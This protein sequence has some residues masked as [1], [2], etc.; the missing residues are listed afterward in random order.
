MANPRKIFLEGTE[1]LSDQVAGALLEGIPSG[2]FD[3]QGTEVW[4]PTSGAARRIRHSLAKISEGKGSGVLSPKFSKPMSALLPLGTSIASRTDREAAWGIVL[5]DVDKSS[6][7]TLF[8]S[9]EVLEGEQ[10]LV[11]A[12]GMMCEL[13]DRLAEGG[14]TPLHPKISEVCGEDADRWREMDPIY[15]SYL[16]V[17]AHHGLKDPNE[18]KVRADV[19]IAPP[20]RLFIACVPDLQ[21]VAQ[22]RASLLMDQGVEVSV[23]VWRPRSM[24]GSFDTWGRPETKEWRDAIIPLTEDQI[25]MAKDPADEASRVVE[26]L[27]GGAGSHALVLGD[28]KI[29][30]AMQGEILR[31]GGSPF[32][33]EGKPL[34]R[35]EAS[36]VVAEWIKFRSDRS[37]RTLRR[38]LES[39]HFSAWI[40]ARCGLSTDQLLACSDWFMIDLLAENLS[41]AEAF[42]KV[43]PRDRE[44]RFLEV[45]SESLSLAPENLVR[46]VWVGDSESIEDVLDACTEV[47]SSKVASNWPEAAEA[48]LVRSFAR[49]CVYSSSEDG[50]T[51]LNGWL[52][53][54]WNAA[55]RLAICGCVEGCLPSTLDGHPFLPD[56]ARAALGI[57][58]NA[59]LRA[60][61][62]Y[63]LTCLIHAQAAREG[64]K[65]LCSFSKF[66]PDGSPSTPSGLLLKCKEEE[67]PERVVKLFGKSSAGDS[68][69]KRK[70][71]WTWLLPQKQQK[72]VL[73]ISPTDFKSYLVCPFR[74]YLSRRLNLDVHDQGVREMDGGQF[75]DLVHVVLRRFAEHSRDETGE[76]EISRA[77]VSHLDDLVMERFGPDPSPAVRVQIQAAKVRLQSFARVQSLLRD[78]GWKII[79]W[80]KKI[81]A[82][83][84]ESPVIGG[85]PLSAVIDRIDEHPELGIRII[86]YK[87]QGRPVTPEKAH[88]QGKSFLDE[89]LVPGDGK[90]RYWKDLQLPLYRKIA[91]VLYPDRPLECAYLALTADPQESRLSVFS[92]NEA[93]MESA[94]RCAEAV[95]LL[96]GRGVFWPPQPLRSSA[97][98]PYGLLFK[99][100]KFEECIDPKTIEFLK[101]VCS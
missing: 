52:E 41:Q 18:S 39:T 69:P 7:A 51:D 9:P 17:L 27:A 40:G 100:G 74:F 59:L 80:E 42:L 43:F 32:L 12:A 91:E 99:D 97:W 4:I 65:I 46:E 48:L 16:S 92:L 21:Q 66:G 83:S 64:G 29:S 13:C 10:F 44:S 26:F 22:K 81:E 96:V 75:G 72:G 55:K 25:V 67:L 95:A 89:A 33:P 63:L 79:A 62:Q 11:G 71:E 58:D 94:E 20:S 93:I 5:R 31:R 54:P 57:A 60:R 3:L 38:L 70:V 61:D 56:Q 85:L 35:T 88:F 47:K 1:S 53:A 15:R 76:R 2:P 87:T 101:G 24:S 6:V 8:P 36:V 19:T 49:R 90:A 78:Q 73:R 28:Q 14:K 23:L 98:D 68:R 82:G 84:P 86:D 50:D 30:G 45:I 77:V 34:A 37:L